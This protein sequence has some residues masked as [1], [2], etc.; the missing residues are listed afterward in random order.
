MPASPPRPAADLRPCPRPLKR[1]PPTA[2]KRPRHNGS[3]KSWPWSMMCQKCVHRRLHR[4]PPILPSIDVQAK[5]PTRPEADQLPPP[6]PVEAPPTD[7]PDALTAQVL[8]EIMA[9]VDAWP[10]ARTPSPASLSLILPSMDEEMPLFPPSRSQ[11]SSPNPRW[12]PDPQL[13]QQSRSQSPHLV[14]PAPNPPTFLDEGDTNTQDRGPNTG[15][16]MPNDGYD[17][18]EDDQEPDNDDD[19]HLLPDVARYFDLTAQD[20]D[21]EEDAPPATAED[22]AFIDDAP[23]MDDDEDNEDDDLPSFLEAK[24]EDMEIDPH[25]LA[26]ALVQRYRDSRAASS[27]TDTAAVEHAHRSPTPDLDDLLDQLDWADI[28]PHLPLHQ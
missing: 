6:L 8:D 3:T 10:N 21:A 23:M 5:S 15:K 22:Q 26:A 12:S 2:Q 20:S 16:G 19:L 18:P 4:T 13:L 24:M 11:T 27:R 9:M 25:E 1:R 17:W 7:S 14:P 28:R